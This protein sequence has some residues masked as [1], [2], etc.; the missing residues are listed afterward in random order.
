MAAN[1]KVIELIYS[2]IDEHNEIADPS[3]TLAKTL[4]TVLF[5]MN[6][7]LDS[8]ELVSLIIAVEDR[9]QREFET[10]I[11]IADDRALSQTRSP[12]ST[13]GKLAEWTSEL[14]KEATDV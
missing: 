9:I 3:K 1:P 13:V 8:L 4:D 2:S 11:S 12:F 7:N 10:D 5:G 14:V 6:G